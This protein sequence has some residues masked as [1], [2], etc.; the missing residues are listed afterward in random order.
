MVGGVALV[1][2]GGGLVGHAWHLGAL[3]G[4]ADATGWEPDRAELIV[5]TSAG[6]VV[7]AELRTGLQPF[8]LLRP[9]VGAAP[10][11]APRPV[12]GPRSLRCAAPGLAARAVLPPWRVR[13]GM[14]TAGLA[15]RGRRDT[16]I[17]GDAIDRLYGAPSR[18]PPAP[19][20][21]CT[22]RLDD[23]RR[24]VFGGDSGTALG[25]AV[26]ASCAMPGF[27][28]PVTID[29]RDHVDGGVWSSTNADLA[30]GRGFD[31]VV[32]SSP[33]SIDRSAS[34]G[35]WRRRRLPAVARLHRLLHGA[36]LQ[37]ELVAVRRGGT[38]VTVLE[39]GAD[40]LAAMGSIAMSMD[41]DRRAAVVGRARATA[42]RHMGA[43]TSGPVRSALGS[44]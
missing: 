23:G 29:G 38:L 35:R 18:W 41:F 44:R 12:L 25:T 11:E 8:E 43:T 10:V 9:G 17:I 37:R 2:G 20:E 6:A 19:L 42:A 13:P 3:A 15:P 36:R 31:L 1:L 26:A 39:P 21:V 27:F 22:T 5:G 24:V 30:A 32:V 4:L 33:M 40:D 34:P 14:L 16:A 7:G 28:C